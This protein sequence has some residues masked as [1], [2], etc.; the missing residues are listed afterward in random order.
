MTN[1]YHS[2]IQ[3]SDP[4]DNGHINSLDN[5][6]RLPAVAMPWLRHQL[7]CYQEG[8]PRLE[9]EGA[10]VEEWLAYQ[11]TEPGQIV[12]KQV[13]GSEVWG[14][15]TP[16]DQMPQGVDLVLGI[17]ITGAFVGQPMRVITEDGN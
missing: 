1:Q 15:L 6:M 5:L 11:D 3:P 16:E 13:S 10:T 2:P 12:V 8:R 9:E 4:L 14:I 17:T 7:A